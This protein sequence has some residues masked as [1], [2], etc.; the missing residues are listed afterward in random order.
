[1]IAMSL[2]FYE[3]F[4]EIRIKNAPLGRLMCISTLNDR[5]EDFSVFEGIKS[6]SFYWFTVV[7]FIIIRFFSWDRELDWWILCP[8]KLFLEALFMSFDG[9]ATFSCEIKLGEARAFH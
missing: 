7:H 9:A 6:M 3:Q 5:F 2:H 4:T 1:M 8:V